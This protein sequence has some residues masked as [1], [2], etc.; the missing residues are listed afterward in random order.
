MLR[1]FITHTRARTPFCNQTAQEFELDNSH[2]PK[3]SMYSRS[4]AP[5]KKAHDRLFEDAKDRR[6][7]QKQREYALEQAAA[8]DEETGQV[9]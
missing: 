3:I 7:R 2:V 4:L 8:R 1:H 9:W 6:R 5:K